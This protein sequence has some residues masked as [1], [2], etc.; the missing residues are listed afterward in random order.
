MTDVDAATGDTASGFFDAG[1]LEMVRGGTGVSSATVG[2]ILTGNNTGNLIPIAA[3]ATGS[4]LVSN[5]VTTI[6]VWDATPDLGTPSALVLT[7]ATGS[8][9][10]GTG[11]ISGGV[12]IET[13]GA[14]PY[15]M[16]AATGQWIMADEAGAAQIDMPALASGSSFCVYSTTAQVI[17][18]NPSGGENIFLAGATIGA[19]DEL[20]SPGALGDFV[21]LLSNGTNWYVLGLSGVWV[22][23]GAT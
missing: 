15:T 19:G 22:D 12:V 20:D 1:T 13:T 5:G 14:T 18:L 16:G 6:P 11:T 4:V 8:L 10:L 17:S 7:N 21:C 23:G 9:A 3:V 2:A